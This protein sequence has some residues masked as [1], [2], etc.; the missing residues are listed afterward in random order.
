MSHPS[1]SKLLS[2]KSLFLENGST[3]DPTDDLQLKMLRIQ[4]GIWH[5]KRRA[6]IV[7]EGFDAAGKGGTIKHLVEKLDPRG[8]R[9]EAIGPPLES[10]Q[11]T[12]YL[13]RFWKALPQPGTIA[14]FDRSWY[15]RVLVEKVDKLISQKRVDQAYEE[16]NHFETTLTQD[17]IDLVKVFLAITPKEQLRRFEA[18]LNDP[19][20]QWKLT[21]ADL[22]AHQEWD[23]YVKVTDQLLKHTHTK[24]HPWHL[25]PAN[26][27]AQAHHETLKAVT[28][29]LG[30]H[31]EW[32]EEAARVLQLNKMRKLM[33]KKIE[34]AKRK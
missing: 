22:Q 1:L 25:I 13:Y 20:K 19:Y 11:K 12:H 24:K 23:Q 14:I 6:I 9:V 33:L 17:G 8:I 15:G 32:M 4:Q 34:K 31:S 18:R 26:S 16:I 29:A 2:K 3:A 21:D 27:K 10:E 5:N 28:S 30:S 7:F